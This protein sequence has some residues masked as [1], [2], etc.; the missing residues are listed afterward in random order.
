MLLP[1]VSAPSNQGESQRSISGFANCYLADLTDGF[2][3]SSAILSYQ[4][5]LNKEREGNQSLCNR[6]AKLEEELK[7]ACELHYEK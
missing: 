4:E 7:N 5:D 3:L 1:Q 2:S 6:L